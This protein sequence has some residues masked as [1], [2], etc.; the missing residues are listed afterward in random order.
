MGSDNNV[1]ARN[2]VGLLLAV[3]FRDYV[4]V[5]Q[6]RHFRRRHHRRGC[7]HSLLDYLSKIQSFLSSPNFLLVRPVDPL[8]FAFTPLLV[9]FPAHWSPSFLPCGGCRYLP[10]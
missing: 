1:P 2:Q 9:G 10:L 8:L 5:L 6:L 7:C 4:D 3:V